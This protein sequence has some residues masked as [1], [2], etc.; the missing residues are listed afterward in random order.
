MTNRYH[1]IVLGGGIESLVAAG[2]LGK[3]GLDV[4]V[5]DGAETVGGTLV[6]TEAVP[7]FRF[8]SCLDSPGY[9]SPQ[10]AADL[11]LAHHGLKYSLGEPL[12]VAPRPGGPTL[13]L[14][15]NPEATA[16]SLR[17]ASPRDAD[18]WRAF[19][20]RI[21]KF[22]G[23]LADIY[24]RPSPRPGEG[25]AGDLMALLRLA[26]RALM[27]NAWIMFASPPTPLE[28]SLVTGTQEEHE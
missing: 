1:V 4:L 3:A 22:A 25:Q 28:T 26:L 5:V 16:N 19:T 7:G 27:T 13:R 24:C 11:A 15:A 18:Q 8:D 12:M 17:Q 10:V 2:Y 23:L 9:L 6:T 20:D 14:S 21:T